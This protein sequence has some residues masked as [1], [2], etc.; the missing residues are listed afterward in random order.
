MPKKL[1]INAIAMGNLK[2]RKKQYLALIL[3]IFLAMIFSCGV[4]FFISCNESSQ[5]EIRNRQMGRQDTIVLNAQD[6]D[7]ST[8]ENSG[9]L[10]G[11]TGYLHILAYGWTE[12]QMK[13]S[14]IGWF[15]DRA[16]ALYYPQVIE[17]CMPQ[18]KGEIAIEQ[19]Q[20][21]RMG[22]TGIQV[23]ETISLKEVPANGSDYLSQQK[24]KT[25][26]L[27]GILANRKSNIAQSE[28]DSRYRA[29]QIPGVFVSKQELVEPGGK[30]SLIALLKIAKP[31]EESDKILN[32][33]LSW[34][35]RIDTRYRTADWNLLSKV[36]N[37][38]K[39]VTVIA[40]LLAFLSG[41]G[42]ANAFASNLKERKKQIGM[43]RAVGATRR[44]II[45][46]F[47]REAVLIALVCTPLSVAAAYWG[48]KGF[49]YWMGDNFIFI[50]SA[51]VLLCGAVF[52]F[53]VVILSALVPLFFVSRIPP[54]Q[55]IRDVELVRKMKH[56]KV[57]SQ[58]IFQM[59]RLL[60]KRKMLF[61]RGRQ[62]AVS[63]ILAFTTVVLLLAID[64]VITWRKTFQELQDQTDYSVSMNGWMTSETAFV[65]TPE[66]NDSI[67][68]SQRQEAFLLPNVEQ[69][70][71][72]KSCRLNL[73]IEGEY[74]QYLKVN[75]YNSWES[76]SRFG[77]SSDV[78]MNEQV[79]VT[80]ENID[81]LMQSSTNPAYDP[82]RQ[83]AGYSTDLFAAD[84]KARTAD[85]L[86][87]LQPTVV[88]GSINLE[89][90]NAGEEVILNAPQK[91]GFY[92]KKLEEDSWSCG[93][94]DLSED[95]LKTMI[96]SDKEKLPYVLAEA[97][98]PFHV[99]D[100]LTLSMLVSD[101]D[102]KPVRKDRTVRVGA[103]LNGVTPLGSYT[104][105]PGFAIYTTVE[106]LDQ[107][108]QTFGYDGVNLK[109]NQEVTP[110]LDQEMQ[111]TLKA[112]FPGKYVES[113]YA[114]N[115]QM[116]DAFH[117]YVL[118]AGA[119]I[120]V[121]STVSISLV[122]NFISAQIRDG[123]RAIGTLR[124]VGA[125]QRD[126]VRS[127]VRQIFYMTV[128]GVVLGTLLYS[129][130]YMGLV[131]I[132]EG[133]MG[134]I[135]LWPAPI[136]FMLIFGICYVHLILQIRKVSSQSIVENIREL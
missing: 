119:L 97:E 108:G 45:Q 6:T 43:L 60:A 61:Q 95:R 56:K 105:R 93:L 58:P 107:F 65:N 100:T 87:E 136:L 114:R 8:I 92:L 79:T 133:P 30:E 70:E 134:V 103:I 126:I 24:D 129:F 76:N 74:P 135:P 11:T 42:I 46:I 12:D 40:A 4:P 130:G 85:M 91:I 47:G 23:G 98:N 106:G 77:T 62:F 72:Q 32:E 66:L 102:G 21:L 63:V 52:G 53:V 117:S 20:L 39:I 26:T 2:H 73:L 81:G 125:S 57:R 18:Q 128:V 112:I 55:A 82:V 10:D 27:V 75:A 110:E 84:C 19:S 88:E 22:L 17:G 94:L 132:Y 89:K 116:L 123:K 28:N 71:G 14:T 124:A 111:S 122:N 104:G 33:N 99:G 69:I 36:Q 50:P 59:D 13:G 34:E 121:L 113:L 67:Q 3:G 101:A 118:M 35:Y 78:L 9:I 96:P 127:F 80:K 68:E 5:K 83:W 29:A 44:Q 37:S 48:V 25:Y 115:E 38:T 15:D 90:L 54:M 1:T 41:F 31:T 16:E 86:L 120:L 64:E 109:L 49:A 51:S 7:L 131:S